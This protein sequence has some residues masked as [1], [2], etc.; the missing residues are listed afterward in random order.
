MI[1]RDFLFFLTGFPPD[2]DAGL[3]SRIT[4]NRLLRN[5]KCAGAIQHTAS[6]AQNVNSAIAAESLLGRSRILLS[7]AWML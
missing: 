3:I 6:E 7:Q 5:A 2:A 4:G 1:S